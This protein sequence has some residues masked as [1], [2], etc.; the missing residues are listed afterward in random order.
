[1]PSLPII[2]N[3]AKRKL[4][5]YATQPVT[6][7]TDQEVNPAING[8]ITD[9]LGTL[10][11][12]ERK[13]LTGNVMI[14]TKETNIINLNID[15]TTNN[16]DLELVVSYSTK[17]D[18]GNAT[19]EY[20]TTA[21]RGLH[22]HQQYPTKNRYVMVEA[23]GTNLQS[24]VVLDGNLRLSKYTQFNTSSQVRDK[25]NRN[26]L[27][28]NDRAVND[29]YEDV[30]LFQFE[31]VQL[32]TMTASMSELPSS[33]GTH[34]VGNGDMVVPSFFTD[35]PYIDSKVVLVSD[36]SD[37]NLMEI[38]GISSN[39][40]YH[41]D[42]INL[43][44]TSN[45][46]ASAHEYRCINRIIGNATGNVTCS[47]STT[48]ETLN[49]MGSLNG[50]SDQCIFASNV[51]QTTY[52]KALHYSGNIDDRGALLK[53]VKFV[54]GQPLVLYK[55]KLIDE[56]VNINLEV[57]QFNVNPSEI[58]CVTIEHAGVH[59]SLNFV[60]KVDVKLDLVSHSDVINFL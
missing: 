33:N 7:Y 57:F 35:F 41:F 58:I 5:S 36:N 29:Y 45:T 42:L 55:H 27:A 54:A 50:I 22:F 1:M 13:R 39:G 18:S 15:N 59:P 3:D 19:V 53:L 32:S 14:D 8:A 56:Q 26:T 47:S 49:Y 4:V 38:Q 25:I 11:V 17:N 20:N 34:I 44:G 30:A 46:V 21:I 51:H 10:E 24:N 23:K 48:G 37:T 2:R 9:F 16:Q 31:N 28:I 12:N 52:V 6:P 40:S 43:N 60:N